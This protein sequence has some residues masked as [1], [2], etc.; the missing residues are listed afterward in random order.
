MVGA[1]CTVSTEVD[2]TLF[3]TKPQFLKII[4]ARYRELES[5]D[6]ARD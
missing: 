3:R 6:M 4:A 2:A 5:F 1:K